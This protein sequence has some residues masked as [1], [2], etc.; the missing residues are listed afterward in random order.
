MIIDVPSAAIEPFE[1]HG[2]PR[3]SISND[4][5]WEMFSTALDNINS[6]SKSIRGAIL[7]KTMRYYIRDALNEA[8]AEFVNIKIRGP[9]TSKDGEGIPVCHITVYSKMPNKPMRHMGGPVWS[10]GGFE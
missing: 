7:I 10:T 9:Y 4:T 1:P 6:Y 8:G 3:L 5:I 2:I